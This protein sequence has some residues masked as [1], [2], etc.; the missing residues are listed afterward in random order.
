MAEWVEA[1]PNLLFQ[2]Y[3]GS[4]LMPYWGVL[5]FFQILPNFKGLYLICAK[6]RDFGTL[7]IQFYLLQTTPKPKLIHLL[8][9]AQFSIFLYKI[10]Q[11]WS[12]FMA[13]LPIYSLLWDNFT[14]SSYYVS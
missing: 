5:F 10:G 14:H 6:F 9:P 12:L 8:P 7:C 4:K 1:L 3:E 13:L 2:I 11:N